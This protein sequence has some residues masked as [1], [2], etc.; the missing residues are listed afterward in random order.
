MYLTYNGGKSVVAERFIKT[1]KNKIYK[2]MTAIS[3][4]FYFNILNE[5]HFMSTIIHILE[6][7]K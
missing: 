4:K 3:K 1:L 2:H 6:P 5:Y 7:L